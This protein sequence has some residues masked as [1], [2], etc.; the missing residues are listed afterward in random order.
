MRGGRKIEP[1]GRCAFCERNGASPGLPAAA[2]PQA[3]NA[4]TERAW[5]QQADDEQ[6]RYRAKESNHPTIEHWRPEVRRHSEC[7]EQIRTSDTSQHPD[8]DV[9]DKS[10][11][12]AADSEPREPARHG[13]NQ[14]GDEQVVV[15][16]LQTRLR[17][18]Q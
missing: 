3:A 8:D 16:A 15:H 1:K 14:Y 6:D 2:A 11:A 10:I 18:P 7:T 5:S 4:L 9:P 17:V 13:S 12:A